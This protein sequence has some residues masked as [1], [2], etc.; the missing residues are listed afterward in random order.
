MRDY[1]AI[2]EKAKQKG[3]RDICTEICDACYNCL[4]H[5]KGECIY[6]EELQVN[7]IL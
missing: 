7:V 6:D 3:Y 5:Q 2:R 4:M 1:K